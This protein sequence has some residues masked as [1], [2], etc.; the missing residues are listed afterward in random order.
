MKKFLFTLCLCFLSVDFSFAR[1][2]T[3][4]LD[5]FVQM[6][7]AI[8]PFAR[9]I[10]K[11]KPSPKLHNTYPRI[12]IREGTSS[13]WSGYTVATS[14]QKPL[15]GSV[16]D[17]SGHWTVPHLFPLTG[18][19]Y[20]SIWVG[21]DG[22]AS[23]TV[24]QIGTEHDWSNGAQQNYAW[25]EMYP[26]NAFEIV[27]FPVNVSDVIG[28]EVEYTGS[29]TFKLT[30]VNYTHQV[31]TVVPSS[32][33]KSTTAARS[34]AE[35]IVEAPY[36]NKVLPLANFGTI[37]LTNCI[38]TIQGVTGSIQSNQW[39]KDA[40]TMTKNNGTIKAIP[41]NLSTDG[42]AFNVTWKHK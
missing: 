34:S 42:E 31:F 12:P 25:F 37:A 3:A 22:Y 18:D 16:T 17:V 6:E 30:L 29:N 10:S 35:W 1:D 33:T 40:L 2:I 7:C 20:C 38:T 39:V 11:A 5:S 4:N 27:G 23:G 15:K 9:K 36:L 32:Y 24:E 26:K 14:L 8:K 28:A 21:I 13:N 41:S 19:T